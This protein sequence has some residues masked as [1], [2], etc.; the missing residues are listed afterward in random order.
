MANPNLKARIEDVLK[1]AFS[2]PF[3]RVH[4]FDGYAQNVHAW[5]V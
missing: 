1:R 4:V 2:A 3:D 5:V